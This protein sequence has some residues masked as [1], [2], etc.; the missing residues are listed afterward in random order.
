LIYDYYIKQAAEILEIPRQE[1]MKVQMIYGP[2]LFSLIERVGDDAL[3]AANG[4]VAGDSFG[5]GHFLTSGGAMAGMVGHSARVLE[6]WRSRDAGI[7]AADAVRR[8]AD[9]I[10][11]DTH[12]WLEVS[13]KEY[14]Q[15]APINFGAERIEQISKASGIASLLCQSLLRTIPYKDL[16]TRAVC[17]H[18]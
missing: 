3:I 11:E 12:G 17:S 1:L 18:C 10:R 4:V 16:S 13:A 2:T 9:K 15:A 5:N 8:L 6:Y 14:S 7:S